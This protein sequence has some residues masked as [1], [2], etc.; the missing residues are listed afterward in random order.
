LFLFNEEGMRFFNTGGPYNPLYH[1]MLS[2]DQRLHE[3]NVMRLIEQ[4]AYFILHAPR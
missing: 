3:E 4:Q 2:A 1:Y